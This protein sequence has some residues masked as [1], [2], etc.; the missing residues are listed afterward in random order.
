MPQLT[1]Q[2]PQQ[3]R[4]AWAIWLASLVALICLAVYGFGLNKRSGVLTDVPT[5]EV[6]SKLENT[7]PLNSRLPEVPVVE[8]ST[9]AANEAYAL[10]FEALIDSSPDEKARYE[11]HQAL[12]SVQNALKEQLQIVTKTGKAEPAFIASGFSDNYQAVSAQLE[13]GFA[14]AQEIKLEVAQ[15]LAALSKQLDG[16][17]AIGYTEIKELMEVSQLLKHE[18][19]IHYISRITQIMLDT[20]VSMSDKIDLVSSYLVLHDPVINDRISAFSEDIATGKTGSIVVTESDKIR[21]SELLS[22]LKGGSD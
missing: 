3:T 11:R 21:A 15:R 17:S 19:E 7:L 10:N 5:L 9:S 20:P 13:S 12:L 18:S 6:T 2:M 1:P 22:Q 4:W 8:P 16:G 14:F